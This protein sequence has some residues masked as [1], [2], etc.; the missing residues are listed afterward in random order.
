[1]RSYHRLLAISQYFVLFT[2]L[3]VRYK[4]WSIDIFDSPERG[5][6]IADYT[7]AIELNSNQAQVYLNRGLVRLL[8]GKVAEADKDFEECL[9]RSGDLKASLE[10]RIKEI[11]LSVAAR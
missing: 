9:K 2:V 3:A 10:S 11:K 8:Q 4:T 7:R 6:A 1:M 5:S